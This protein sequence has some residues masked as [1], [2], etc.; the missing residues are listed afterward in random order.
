[1]D[2]LTK[3]FGG[4]TIPWFEYGIA[5]LILLAT[6]VVSKVV[7][8]LLKGRLTRWAEKTDSTV[9]DL[10]IATFRKPLSFLIY[11][12]GIYLALKALP[13]SQKVA[14]SFDN[15]IKALI[16]INFA[17]FFLKGVDLLIAFLKPL[18]ER[19]E[20]KLDD[21]LL[22]ILSRTVKI[23]IGIIAILLII[24]NFGYNIA[25]LIAG[26]GIGGLAVALAAQETLS[27]FFGSITLFADRPFHVGDL[28]EVDNYKGFVEGVGFRSTRIRTLEGTQ[29]TLPNS[30]VANST[31]H[32][33]FKRPTIRKYC[34]IGIT[35]DSG[36][37]K[38]KKAIQIL[39]EILEERKDLEE[40]KMV[41]F[42]AFGAHSLDIHVLYRVSGTDWAAYLKAEEEI[43]L[44]ILRRF[45]EE[46][47][48]IAFPTQT[49]YVKGTEVPEEAFFKG[50][51]KI[52]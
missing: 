11:T 17:Y 45:D 48:E 24:Q 26:L 52:P 15:I 13:L 34:I 40:A 30:K 10:I 31:I 5:F 16:A 2:F 18:T 25:S 51:G 29:V 22:P 14:V 38:M 9:D 12:L 33:I 28:V 23:F 35:Y 32:N 39:E 27:N 47:I 50:E 44:E 1:M 49:L 3:T 6:G 46:G 20:S 43:N 36:Y 7:N 21:Q 41:R 42:R 37:E 8:F 4:G 19:T